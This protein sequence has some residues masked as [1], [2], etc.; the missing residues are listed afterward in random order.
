MSERWRTLEKEATQKKNREGR[1]DI[2]DNSSIGS[3]D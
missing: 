3:Y 2:D 1:I